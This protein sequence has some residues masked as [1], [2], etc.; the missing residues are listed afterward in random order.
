MKVFNKWTVVGDEIIINNNKFLLCRCECGTEKL[1]R[2][3]NLKSGISKNCG[4]VRN[5]KT[6]L[7]NT[8]HGKR[9]DKIWTVWNCM[10]QRCYNK[11]NL[12]YKNYGGRGI[13]VCD[14]W[15]DDFMSFVKDM[16]DVPSGM[17]IDRIDNN[18]KYCKEN[19]RWATKTEQ[20]RNRRSNVKINGVCLSVISKELGGTN[21]LVG[22][23]L[24]RGWPI[25]KAITLQSNVRI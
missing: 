7:R 25:E 19:C 23:R 18:G 6:T 3:K 10:K 12:G 22:K 15:K 21:D 8:A 1:V 16:G 20:N 13:T 24:R 9:Y 5:N 17:S 14:E 2:L 4:C 11:N